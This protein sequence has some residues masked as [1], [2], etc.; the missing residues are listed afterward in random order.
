MSDKQQNSENTVESH[1]LPGEA[2]PGIAIAFGACALGALI[3]WGLPW[4]FVDRPGAEVASLL[5]VIGGLY[6]G[7][8][9]KVEGRTGFLRWRRS[10]GLVYLFVGFWIPW[11][12][13][14]EATMPWQPYSDQLLAQAKD[15][16]RPVMIDF[17]AAWCGPCQIMESQVFSR[18][19]VVD[20]ADGFLT[21]KADM[22]DSSDPRVQETLQRFSIMAFPTVVFIGPDGEE[23]TKL[24]L[25][26]LE[27]ADRFEQRL[28]A[29]Q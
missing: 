27:W 5:L 15:Q 11:G 17:T 4:V 16:G 18:Q 26:G 25:V 7:F 6:L 9:K 10:L 29:V 12:G 1:P 8:L 21:L 22:T 19:K 28:S 3:A 23:R 14:P 24:R 20:A 13:G 2:V